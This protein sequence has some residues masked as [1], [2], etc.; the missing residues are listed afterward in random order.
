MGQSGEGREEP[1][2][3]LRH[4]ART[5]G[6]HLAGGVVDRRLRSPAGD[7][8]GDL[9]QLSNLDQPVGGEHGFERGHHRSRSRTI[10]ST[11]FRPNAWFFGLL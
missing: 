4:V 8:G 10:S 3:V 11:H 6:H 2:V 7:V 1:E 9:E 5:A